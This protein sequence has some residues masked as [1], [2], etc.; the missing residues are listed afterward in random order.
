[1]PGSHDAE[2]RYNFDLIAQFKKSEGIKRTDHRD[3]LKK[4]EIFVGLWGLINCLVYLVVQHMGLGA[5]KF[6]IFLLCTWHRILGV[7]FIL[8]SMGA[9][10]GL[11]GSGDLL[12]VCNL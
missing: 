11:W 4:I 10:L 2:D 7:K 12:A 6:G 9:K 5:R 8:L 1:M 3:I